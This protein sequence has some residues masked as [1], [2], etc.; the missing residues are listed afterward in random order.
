MS[1]KNSQIPSVEKL[2]ADI[3][4]T[5]TELSIKRE[6]SWLKTEPEIEKMMDEANFPTAPIREVYKQILKMF[7]YKGYTDG[8]S[9]M[10]EYLAQQMGAGPMI[11]MFE[12]VMQQSKQKPENNTHY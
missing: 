11:D 10:A 7:W 6:A 2:L 5:Q 8:T 1:S 4:H 12:L 3:Q 9:N